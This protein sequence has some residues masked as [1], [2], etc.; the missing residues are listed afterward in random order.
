MMTFAHCF[1]WYLLYGKIVQI[2]LLALVLMN[3]PVKMYVTSPV[4][5]SQTLHYIFYTN[6]QESRAFE[7][8]IKMKAISQGTVLSK[9]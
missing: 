8:I 3:T 9:H 4:Q 2:L 5:K 1:N 7:Q 6:G